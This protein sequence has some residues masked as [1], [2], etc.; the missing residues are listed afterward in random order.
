[1]YSESL[2]MLKLVQHLRD[3][4]HSSGSLMYFVLFELVS[5]DHELMCGWVGSYLHKV[6]QVRG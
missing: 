5:K 1:L 6:T 4:Y 3:K 2:K